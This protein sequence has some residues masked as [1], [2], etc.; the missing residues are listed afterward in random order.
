MQ[1]LV[2]LTFFSK[3][4]EEKPLEGRLDPLGKGRVKMML[5]D[6]LAN[7]IWMS[8]SNESSS[9]LLKVPFI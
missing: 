8:L 2:F 3:F 5:Y 9:L 6:F 4:I 1:S 7:S